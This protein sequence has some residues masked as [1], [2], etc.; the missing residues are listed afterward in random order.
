MAWGP[1]SVALVNYSTSLSLLLPLSYKVKKTDEDQSRSRCWL[2]G[3]PSLPL[4]LCGAAQMWVRCPP[5]VGPGA[6]GMPQPPSMSPDW[7]K[8]GRWLI[9]LPVIGLGKKH[10]IHFWPMRHEKTSARHFW[11][12]CSLTIG[13]RWDRCSGSAPGPPCHPGVQTLFGF[14][15]GKLNVRGLGPLSPRRTHPWSWR[16]MRKNTFKP[17]CISSWSQSWGAPN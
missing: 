9:P 6:S 12:R 11:E 14:T 5:P 17:F 16:V 15:W 13:C 4:L 8:S 3:C 7:A 2:R 10:V 1:W